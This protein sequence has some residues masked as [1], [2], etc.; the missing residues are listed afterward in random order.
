ME[1]TAC[2]LCET[3]DARPELTLRDLGSGR[4]ERF[5][6]VCCRRCGLRYL[7]PRPSPSEM[8]AYYP[9][10]YR[11]YRQAIEDEP[12]AL[13]RWMRRRNI[14]RRRLAAERHAPRRPGRVLDVGCATGIFL[15]EMQAAGWQGVGVETGEPAARY[16]R[17]RFGLT[18]IHGSL[19]QA[20]LPA[21]AFD[22][23]TFWD[24]LEHTHNP[25]VTLERAWRLLRREGVVVATV[26]NYHSLDR[27][28]F[29]P[30]WIGFDA[31]RHLTV[32]APDTLR[33]MLEKTG[34]DVLELRC[35]FGG[36]F[37][38]AASLRHWT[39]ASLP[40]PRVRRL[41][42]AVT[43]LPGLRLPFEPLFAVVDRLGWGSE[44]MVV[45]RKK[46]GGR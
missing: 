33:R 23:I 32:F 26:P 9:P 36:F 14:R 6:L 29:G 30:A 42:A 25:R 41:C 31:P 40:W 8:G 18:V 10:D 28:L 7:N 45:A 39:V 17:E 37:S 24:V 13:M 35:N 20:D 27:I 38:F 1:S 43:D 19:E 2:A 3:D 34:F 22:L 12:W 15:A 5:N 11:P 21:A 46:E 16:A 4:P 44:L